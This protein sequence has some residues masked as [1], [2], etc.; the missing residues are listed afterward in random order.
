MICKG[1]KKNKNKKAHTLRLIPHSTYKNL[2]YY[3]TSFKPSLL[4]RKSL[5]KKGKTE[6]VIELELSEYQIAC[7][8]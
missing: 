3:P 7:M 4:N 6:K 5:K 8:I 1:K 2:I